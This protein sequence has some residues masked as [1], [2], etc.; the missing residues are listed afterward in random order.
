M[1]SSVHHFKAAEAV[2]AKIAARQR[3]TDH[4]APGPE[5][6]QLWLESAKL[7]TALAG[8]ALAAEA[9]TTSGSLT[10]SLCNSW[11]KALT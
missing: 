4:P 6:Y 8:V 1:A 9:A 10:S 2:L 3:D 7:H 11:A 5:T